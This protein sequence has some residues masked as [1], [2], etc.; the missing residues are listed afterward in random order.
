MSTDRPATLWHA[1]TAL[2]D[3]P[4]LLGGAE[5]DIVVIGGGFAGL[6]AAATLAPWPRAAR[7]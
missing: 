3:R 1:R 6:S 7:A 2:P 5:A 4:A